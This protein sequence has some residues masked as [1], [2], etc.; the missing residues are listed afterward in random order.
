MKK[1]IY[2]ILVWFFLLAYIIYFS[3]F[4]ILRY[5][6]LYASY[7]DLGI[8]HQTVYNTYMS[9][10]TGDWSRFLELTDPSGPGQIKRMAVHNDILLALLSPFFFLK[11]GPET[12]L[13]IQTVVI[14]LGALAIF[15]IA[16]IAFQKFNNSSLLSLIF[17]LSYLLYFPLERANIFDF[18]AV[19]LATTFLLFMFYF[20]T[21]KKYFFSLIFFILSL[22]SKEQV[23]LTTMTF[24]VYLFLCCHC[25]RLKGAKQ[26]QFRG[27]RG[28]F[29]PPPRRGPRNDIARLFS[30]VVVFLS[31][32]WFTASVFVI[33][34]YFRRGDHFSV[35]K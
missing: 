28:L 31:L 9:V 5:K 23:A 4:S 14:A 15:K 27:L 3:Y 34:P 26:S 7:Y 20:W 33:I 32:V 13:I 35:P 1:N 11:Q 8:M 21:V 12:L 10:K 17:S 22:L 18:H 6:T 25:E 24:G 19:T 16:L 30:F 2:Q 29:R